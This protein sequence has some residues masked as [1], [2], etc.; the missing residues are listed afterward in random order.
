[1]S[2]NRLPGVAEV[3]MQAGLYTGRRI[4]ARVAGNDPV[5]AFRY[6]DLGSAAYLSR[7]KAVVSAGPLRFGGFAGWLAWLF[8]HITF[9]TGYRNRL[10]AV[11]AWTV[12]FTRDTR[13]E[14]TYTTQ[15]ILR[16]HDVY[17][18]PLGGEP[19]SDDNRSGRGTP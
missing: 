6:Y 11:L 4:R 15:Q 1:M 18:R 3:A 19:T 10:A 17:D 5:R 12:A 13:H 9:L 8:I 16:L 2:L 14:R 7:G